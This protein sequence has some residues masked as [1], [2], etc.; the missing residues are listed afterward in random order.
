[1]TPE[2]RIREQLDKIYGGELAESTWYRLEDLINKYQNST[3]LTRNKPQ[4]NVLNLTQKDAILITYGDQLLDG[5]RKPLEC[6]DEFLR[7]YLKE[8]ISGVHI[9]P[10]FPFSS[11]DGFS[12]IDYREVDPELGDWSNIE[13]IGNNFK[14][15]FDAVINHVSR[16]S[17]WFLS[18]LRQESPYDKY[19]IT[20][21]PTVDLSMVFRPRAFPLLTC[22][23]SPSGPVYVWTTFSNDQ[24]DLNFSNP[25]VLL[26]V[27]DLLLFYISKGAQFIRLDAIAYLWKEIGTTSIHLPQTHSVIK[28]WRAVLD[29]LAP[30][31]VLIT[32]TNVPHEENIS[33]FGK[34]NNESAGTDEAQMVYQFPLAP[35]ILHTFQKSDVTKLGKWVQSLESPGLF[36]N[37][38]ASHDGIGVMPAKGILCQSEI[39]DIVNQTLAHG[40]KVS[41]KSNPDGSQSVYELNIT[42]YDWLDDSK[43]IL[44]KSSLD[45]FLASQAIML[46][47]AGIPGIY[48]HSLIGSSNCY[49]CVEETGRRRSINREK[50]KYSRLIEELSNPDSRQKIILDKYIKLLKVR[51]K[52][53]AFHPKSS[54]RIIEI[55]SNVFCLLR[56]EETN[57]PILCLI[58]VASI[59]KLLS[60]N[61]LELKL[62][63]INEAKELLSLEKIYLRNNLLN[64][65]LD[66]YQVKWFS[67]AD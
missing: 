57:E 36:F 44:E 7:T 42:L 10:F 40:G 8:S 14:L 55:D 31:V 49:K 26:E 17:K 54:Q 5:S 20:V 63:K 29:I 43:D 34:K 28:I 13:Q 15:M 6:L 45:R 1:M 46:S 35:L 18:F 39:D 66:P 12:V 60:L 56:G 33:Y 59:R 41:Y 38:I 58:N 21:D 50:F 19:F 53:V 48:F 51:S 22:V 47:L 65:Q 23:D 16:E 32:E 52:R 37:F 24:I 27:I 4:E 3:L 64:V 61:L 25:A 9:L 67:I 11:D 62:P 2:N 30:W